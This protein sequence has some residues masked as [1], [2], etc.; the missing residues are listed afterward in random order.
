MLIHLTPNLRP[1]DAGMLITGA[2]KLIIPPQTDK[3]SVAGFCSADCLS[4]RM[5]GPVKIVGVFNHMHLLGRVE[6]CI[7]IQHFFLCF[8]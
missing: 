5:T 7:N 3:H 6:S 4:S 1:N 2:E 8:S